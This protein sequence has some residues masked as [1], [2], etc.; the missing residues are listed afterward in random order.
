[1]K[2]FSHFQVFHVQTNN[3]NNKFMCFAV[4]HS[5]TSQTFPKHLVL[6]WFSSPTSFISFPVAYLFYWSLL[7]RHL[8]RAADYI[9]PMQ[10]VLLFLGTS[11]W[12]S[13]SPCFLFLLAILQGKESIRGYRILLQQRKLLLR[14]HQIQ[15]LWWLEKLNSHSFRSYKINQVLYHQPE[16]PFIV[17]PG[18]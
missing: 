6:L 1:M 17:T 14:L 2:L 5:K 3:N 12:T 8:D 4:G 10:S 7:T 11:Q 15:H 18:T 16:E 13:L 9:Q